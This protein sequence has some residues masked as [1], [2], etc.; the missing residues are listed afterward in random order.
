[1][2][3]GT[4]IPN[5]LSFRF[6]H[7]RDLFRELVIRDMK[8]RYKRSI[9]GLG[10]SLLNPLAQL[11]VYRF[12]FEQVLPANVP[13]FTS[14]LFSGVLVWNWFHMSM[15]VATTTVVDN[16]ELIKRPGFPIAIL[17]AV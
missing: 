7:R 17:P 6:T 4:T 2:N 15:V 9:L 16:R 11:L 1:M 12:I 3:S 5:S 10:W 13:N 8:L 14:F